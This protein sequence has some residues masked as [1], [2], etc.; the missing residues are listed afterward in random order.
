MWTQGVLDAVFIVKKQN[1]ETLR[2]LPNRILESII[3]LSNKGSEQ[4]GALTDSSYTIF[5]SFYDDINYDG[6]NYDLS[7]NGTIF[8]RTMSIRPPTVNI[9]DLDANDFPD[10]MYTS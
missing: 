8:D 6:N 2:I 5:K 7:I 3:S 1:K 4:M 9:A 10:I